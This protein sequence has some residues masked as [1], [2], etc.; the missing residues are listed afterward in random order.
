MV[1]VSGSTVWTTFSC[2]G[3]LELS[4]RDGDRSTAMIG[5]RL[6]GHGSSSDRL[7]GSTG[8]N[9]YRGGIQ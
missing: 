1:S 4:A 6:R 3:T 7:L 2:S 5:T 9:A 8:T